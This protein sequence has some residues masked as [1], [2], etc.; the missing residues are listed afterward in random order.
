MLSNLY[1]YFWRWATWKVFDAHAGQP[2]GIVAFVTTSGYTTG[3]GF[4]GMREYLR[5]TADEGWIIDLS[6][7]GH[8]PDVS[9]RVF[10]GVQQPLCIGVFARY[11]EGDRE[12]PAR[13]HHLS[14]SGRRAEKFTQLGEVTLDETAWNDCATGWQDRLQ[15]VGGDDWLGYPLVGDLMP[16]QAPGVKPNRTWVYDPSPG[17]LRAR[18]ER[19]I[20][21]SR[22]DKAKLFKESD[23]RKLDSIVQPIIG[24]VHHDGVILDEAGQCPLPV[25]VAYRSFDRQ[26]VI[27]DTRVQERP[28]PELWQVAGDSQVFVVEQH[29]QP[30]GAGPGLVFTAFVPDMDH[31]KGSAGGRVLPLYRD[32]AAGA[33]N[34]A[35]GLL[36]L[37]TERLG[38][39]VISAD[40]LS[41]V[42]AVTAHNGYTVRFAEELRTPG[43]RVPLTADPEL[44]P[45]QADLL[46]R[47]C[48]G[49]LINV[50]DLEQTRVFPVAPA[51][52]KPPTADSRDAPTLL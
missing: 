51:V 41:Y 35:P 52:R 50:T 43:V 37:L 14:V 4:A 21:A 24:F 22:A 3:P 27:P 33:A 7:E 5:R 31:F 10:P 34:L 45:D 46:D 12:T 44:E 49:P 39:P 25:R 9:T 20:K 42:A 30:L 23:G 28:R 17:V 1:V 13:I 38:R 11:G 32:R 19:L 18:W 47:I 29:A 16:W 2:S 48:A 40:L 36:R 6:P 26:W 15:P 8:Q